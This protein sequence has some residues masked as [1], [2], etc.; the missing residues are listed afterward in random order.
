M[1]KTKLSG[2]NETRARLY[3]P[4][5]L[6]ALILYIVFFIVPSLA[7]VGFSLTK[8]AGL[9]SEMS[10]NGVRNYTR[11]F[12]SEPFRVAFFNT[13]TLVVVGGVTVF[14][15]SFAA[16]IVLRRMRGRTFIRSVIFVPYILSPIAI[17]VAVGFLFNPTG[18]LNVLLRGVGLEELAMPWLS[19]EWIFRI[20]VLGFVWSVSGFYVA[21]MM[22]GVDSIPEELYE[23]ASLAGASQWQQFTH[24][25]FPLTRDILATAVVL[26]V[27]NGMKVFEIVI[28]FT[29]T[30]GTPAVESRTVAVQQYLTV[31][32]G[33]DG[34]P[35]LGYASAIG[36][37]I[38]LLSSILVVLVRRL[39]RSEVY[40]R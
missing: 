13:I 40:E 31:T 5:L 39:L 10:W 29:G 14:A 15:A 28:A 32:G 34:T 37:V 24:V 4:F 12:A 35:D 21:L 3:L 19:P 26:W 27:I 18:A 30:A 33:R 23:A 9:G 17:G 11:L 20:I 6:P 7:S 16:M 8:W 1:T 25:T 36:V 38:F 2:I 22:T